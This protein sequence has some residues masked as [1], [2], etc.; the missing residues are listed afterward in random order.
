MCT[1]QQVS[2]CIPQRPDS[3]AIRRMVIAARFGGRLGIIKT[4]LR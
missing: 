3:P 1:L 4:Q 2:F